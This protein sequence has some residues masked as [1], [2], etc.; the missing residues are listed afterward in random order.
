MGITKWKKY[1]TSKQLDEFAD[2]FYDEDYNTMYWGGC[3]EVYY[4]NTYDDKAI[5]QWRDV[6]EYG[7]SSPNY[8]GEIILYRSGLIDIVSDYVITSSSGNQG[9]ISS[10]GSNV[11]ST[12]GTGDWRFSTDIPIYVNKVWTNHPVVFVGESTK[13]IANVTGDNSITG[14][15]FN[16]TLP[17][18]TVLELGNGT[19]SGSLM[20]LPNF[21]KAIDNSSKDS[22]ISSEKNSSPSNSKT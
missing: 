12:A 21:F 1:P 5:F 20:L 8:S 6:C 3:G 9:I 15:Y 11:T 16:I 13:C 17:N 4:D 2:A 19:V 22:L 7:E 18:S 14:V 10:A